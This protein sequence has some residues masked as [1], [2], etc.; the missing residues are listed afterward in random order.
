MN[1]RHLPWYMD[2]ATACGCCHLQF[3]TGG[4]RDWHVVACHPGRDGR[5]TAMEW[6]NLV[7]GLLIRLVDGLG[8]PALDTLLEYARD[9]EM[10]LQHPFIP[11]PEEEEYYQ[12][13]AYQR[14]L[15]HPHQL[16]SGVG[17]GT[18]EGPVAAGG[19]PRSVWGRG[20]RPR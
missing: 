16:P 7:G 2:P 18:L 11:P 10:G 6:T 9:H 14:A 1:A 13:L 12:G 3:L 5:L 19:C 4:R 17:Y 8:L 15:M 20:G